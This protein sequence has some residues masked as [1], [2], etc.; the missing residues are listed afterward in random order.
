MSKAI[1]MRGKMNTQPQQR[2]PN[3]II[4]RVNVRWLEV[5]GLYFLGYG[6]LSISS[7]AHSR[8][9]QYQPYQDDLIVALLSIA[10]SFILTWAILDLVLWASKHRRRKLY[11]TFWVCSFMPGILAGIA[12]W[13]KPTEYG[14]DVS[15][16]CLMFMLSGISLKLSTFPPD[17]FLFL[18][19]ENWLSRFEGDWSLRERAVIQSALSNYKHKHKEIIG[20]WTPWILV[21]YKHR[22]EKDFHAICGTKVALY[23]DSVEQLAQAIQRYYATLGD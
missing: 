19:G 20:P 5:I 10:F 18:R 16:L 11:I 22:N 14:R 2:S 15:L 9:E 12:F 6:V 23:G 7:I 21:C 4:S 3:E 17:V 8:R 1:L 13:I